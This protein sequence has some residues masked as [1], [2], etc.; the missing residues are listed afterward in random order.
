MSGHNTVPPLT[1]R[2]SG[3]YIDEATLKA[4]VSDPRKI[5]TGSWFY[6]QMLALK[7]Q[8]REERL[9]VCRSIRLFCENFKCGDC[10][11]HCRNYVRDN[12]PELHV[13]TESGLF[14]WVVGFRNAVQTR[15]GA[16]LYD[17][18]MVRQLYTN[19][20]YMVCQEGCG[21]EAASGATNPLQTSRTS[22]GRD[23]RADPPYIE[24]NLDQKRA[25]SL[26]RSIDRAQVEV[27]PPFRLYPRYK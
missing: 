7:A 3:N 14:E 12:P 11:G 17:P 4:Q 19:E 27:Q 26:M 10:Q 5:G 24:L 1:T 23:T 6:M 15:L 9:W 21:G 16:P 2:K 25:T 8:S 13:D 20:E 22:G 18:A